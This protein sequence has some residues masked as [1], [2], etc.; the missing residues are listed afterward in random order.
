METDRRRRRE[1]GTHLLHVSVVG[2][3]DTLR[4]SSR[5]RASRV[6]TRGAAAGLSVWV[7]Q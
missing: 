4:V 7:L 3:A 1:E 5:H 2:V 6:R